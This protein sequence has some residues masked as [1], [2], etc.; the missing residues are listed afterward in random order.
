MDASITK[1]R[2][3]HALEYAISKS[4]ELNKPLVVYFG[5]TDNYPEANK[6][7]YYFMLEGLKEVQFSLKE[8]GIKMVIRHISP[9]VGTVGLSKDA[10]LAVVDM[11]YLKIQ[12]KWHDYA[13]EY[14]DCP[15]IQ[16]E[17]DVIVPVEEASQK[18]EYYAATTRLLLSSTKGELSRIGFSSY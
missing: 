5:I 17:S 15:L 2:L 12:K 10:S 1:K 4:N 16:V 3:Y 14:V 7:H 6:R 18:E 9:E 13:S 11:G 8:R